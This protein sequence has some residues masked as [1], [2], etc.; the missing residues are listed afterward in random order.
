MN[1]KQHKSDSILKKRIPNGKFLIITSAQHM[2]R[3]QYCF[4]QE[5]INTTA[6]PTDCTTSYIN[7]NFEYLFLPRIDALEVWE[8]LLHEW[9]GYIVYKI[10]F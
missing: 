2:R 1:N 10:R 4:K 7:F 9:I 8:T 5:N 3:A 6:F